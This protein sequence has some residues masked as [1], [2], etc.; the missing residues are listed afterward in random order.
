VPL[1][2]PVKHVLIGVAALAIGAIV[3]FAGEHLNR[4]RQDISAR[5]RLRTELELLANRLESEI[6]ASVDLGR[7]LGAAIGARGGITEREFTESCENILR[8]EPKIRNIALIVGSIIAYNCPVAKNRATI[9]TDLRTRRDQWSSFERMRETG[10]P[11][12]A[13]PLNLVQGGWTIVARVPIFLGGRI[14]PPVFWGALSMPLN[15]DGL[16]QQAGLRAAMKDIE[17]SIRGNRDQASPP[18][19]LLGNADVFDGNPVVVEVPFPDGAWQLAAK[20]PATRWTFST[21][22]PFYIATIVVAVLCATM[23]FAV[24]LFSERRR[25]LEAESNR[26]RD[27]LRAFMENSPIAMYVK[28]LD[29]RYIDLNAEARS[30][31]AIGDRPYVGRTLRDFFDESRGDELAADD[32]LAKAG[33]VVR[34]ER[35]ANRR[36][37]YL[38]EREIKF[39]VTD[40]LGKVV[41]IGGYVF[42]ITAGKETEIK[43]VRALRTAE[44]ANRAKSEFLATMSHEL[45]TPLNAIIGFSDVI[46][47]ELFGAV[48]NPTYEGYINDIHASGRHLLDL[49]GGIIDLSAVESGHIEV[50]RESVAPAALIS[51]C[52]AMIE[53]LAHERQ[54][55]LSIVDEAKSSCLADMRLLRQVL[56]NLAS[57]AA[58]YTPKGGRILIATS[59]DAEM[60]TFRVS[61]NGVGMAPDEIER[62]MQP[63]TRLGDPMRAEVGGS[64]IG[65]A[66]VKRLVELMRGRLKITSTPGVGTTVEISMPKAV[67][68]EAAAS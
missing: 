3:F 23:F 26:N 30:A 24:A 46:R 28:D 64:G 8:Q 20:V 10:E 49:L 9:G 52:R 32:N 5:N 54:H 1:S 16:F 51:D 44:E 12:V 61:D 4:Q 58:K 19:I 40:A 29:G 39:P 13:G 25:R 35:N 17:L 11:D 7:G 48:G 2:R 53:A 6:D 59:D 31:F 68:P 65:L 36:Q 41:A 21:D 43:L 27:L 60:V 37:G 15:V 38:W 50:K 22:P 33:E 42:D 63:F 56:L 66:L 34:S 67:A 57:N 18:E 14:R 47:R 45:R 55:D 62:A